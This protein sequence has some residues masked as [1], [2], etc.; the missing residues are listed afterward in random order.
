M[1]GIRRHITK[2]LRRLGYEPIR[3]ERPMNRDAY[4][5]CNINQDVTNVQQK[6]LAFV[7]IRSAWDTP[8]SASEVYH[9]NILHQAAMLQKLCKMGYVIDFYSCYNCPIALTA[10]AY[11][12]KYD[13]IFG[14]GVQYIQ[15]CKANPKAKKILFITENAPWVV[16]EKYQERVAY[17]NTRHPE[18]ELTDSP[19]NDFY[20]DEMFEI[21]DAGIAVTGSYNLAGIKKRLS[22]T[23]RLN[24]NGL[25]NG[26]FAMK[27]A[28]DYEKTRKHFVWFG[29]RGFVH[30][31]LDILIDAFNEL[32]ELQ[33]DVYGID[34]AEMKNVTIP[35][36]V[37][38]C[39]MVNVMSDV[40]LRNVVEQ[41]S[42]VVS[43]SCS[44]GMQT[45]LATC[46]LHGLIPI[47]TKE[48]GIDDQKNIVL[49]DAFDVES[50]KATL[51]KASRMPV[52]EVKEREKKIYETAKSE[53]SVENFAKSFKEA[54]SSH[55]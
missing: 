41:C 31:G 1:S 16:R 10:E 49:F 13:V 40:F 52:E 14:S 53:F 30:K 36:N 24:V 26:N 21:S 12:D 35:D 29:S 11:T 9:P 25:Q 4:P 34:E 18:I 23:I 43:L 51:L 5:I 17:F 8:V 2:I 39:G 15:L 54:I 6:R 42:F 47:V 28:K 45:G 20:N 3:K 37:K 33:L 55:L 22:H 32:P 44:E 27:D 50:V 48:C 46:M 19:R 38:M 7:Y